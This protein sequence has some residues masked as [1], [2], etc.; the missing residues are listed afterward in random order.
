MKDTG[1][2]NFRRGFACSFST[3]LRAVI[4]GESKGRMNRNGIG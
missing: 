4:K 1:S 2:L 3:E